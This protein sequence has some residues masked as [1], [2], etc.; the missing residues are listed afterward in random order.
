MLFN[1]MG[2][3]IFFPTVALIYYLLPH[4]ARYLWLL[5]ASWYFYM[6]WNAVY[7]LLLLSCTVV[8]YVAGLLL[9]KIKSAGDDGT[10]RH[11]RQRVL[12]LSAALAVSLGLLGFFKYA[13]FALLNL[14]RLLSVLRLPR[15]TWEYSIVLPVGISFYTLQALGYLIDVYRGDIYAE[16]NFF[17]YALFLAFFPQLVAGPVERSRNLLVQLYAPKR[18]DWENLRRGFLL[19]L[20]GYFLKVVIADRAAVIVNTVYEEPGEYAGFLVAA[21]TVF[22]AVQIYCD[23]YGYSVIAR[24]AARVLGIELMDNFNAP[25]FSQ[26]VK[27]FWR[28][29]H[30]SLSGWFRDYLYIPLGGNR[31]GS[32]RRQVNLLTVFAVSG[33]WHG[34]SVSYIAWGLLN[35]IW[36]AAEDL[37]SYVKGAL[38]GALR[39]LGGA[40]EAGRENLL[41]CERLF[42]RVL[43][44]GLIC[45]AWVFFR[46]GDFSNALEMLRCMLR[47]DWIA[48]VDGSVYELGVNREYFRVLCASILLLG[49]VD[50]RKYR[51][52]DMASALLR[53]RWWFRLAAEVGL[54]FVILLFGCYGV[55]YDTS[56]F[57]Y[58]QF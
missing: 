51:G 42:K 8:T 32:F 10:A 29:W 15:F 24:G 4:K 48:I 55:E 19:M 6:Q 17:R 36:Q 45:L 20:W 34:A 53:Q 38:R 44:F 39:R 21:A 47:F 25:Y 18:F 14:N 7:I 33:L 40:G 37:L 43:T 56:E 58:F 35:G 1:S 11:R 54:V 3:L 50:Y 13:D 12:I 22:F 23:F 5:A 49:C 2:F 9:E 30:I 46:A 57:I 52:A 28:R 26:S 41:F 16:R 31:K 27:E